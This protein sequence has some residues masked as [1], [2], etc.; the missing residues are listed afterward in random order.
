M[1]RRAYVI[2]ALA[3]LVALGIGA[4]AYGLRSEPGPPE[5]CDVLD[6]PPRISPDYSGVVIP[7]NI[8]PMNFRVGEP[9]ERYF[10]RIRSSR[11]DPIEVMSRTA[12][13]VIPPGPWAGLLGANHGESLQVDVY[14]LAGGMWRRFKTISNTIA[15][16]EIDSHLVYRLIRALFNKWSGMGI[17]DRDLTGYTEQLV[18]DNGAF[19]E[20]CVNCHTFRQNAPGDMMLHTRGGAAGSSTI[21]TRDGVPAK[22]DTRT[23]F[24]LTGYT[25]WHPNGKLLVCAVVKVRQFFHTA[26]SEVRDVIDLDSTLI[27]YLPDEQRVAT[28]GSLSRKD[29]LETYPCWS[30]DGRHLYF[31]SA[32]KLWSDE[33]EFPPKRFAE[34]R[35]DLMRASYDAATGTWGQPETLLA[36]ADTGKSI[37][38]ARVSPDGRWLLFCMADYGCFPIF[39]RE[40]DLYLM[41]LR[42]RH[43][44]RPEINSDECDSWHSWSSNGRW[45]VFSSKRGNGLFARPH[46]SYVEDD[47]TVRKPFVLPQRDPAFYESFI[48]TYNV[49]ELVSGPVPVRGAVLSRLIATPLEASETMPVTSP[50][51]PAH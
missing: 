22:V 45:I 10:V 14:V 2:I 9:G 35:Y 11:G 23:P 37:T 16:E 48:K 38:Q 3:G 28:P 44:R 7:P 31:S 5:T 4:A 24:G 6:R 30:P 19:S 34:V 42:T 25:S 26:R 40:C 43:Y 47:G 18:V 50:S 8:A 33:A 15:H 20:G 12:D 51:P 39:N 17:Y 27:C 49:P 29:R 46:F 21:L 36:S 13:M 41:D 32:E 1:S